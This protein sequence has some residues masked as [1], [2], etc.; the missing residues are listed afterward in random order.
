MTTKQTTSKMKNKKVVRH[1][2]KFMSK[3]EADFYDF[4][5]QTYKAEEIELQPKFEL[6]PTFIKNGVT[7]RAI[8]YIADFRIGNLIFD[9]KGMKTLHFIL[10]YKMFEYKNPDLHLTLIKQCPIKYQQIYGRWIEVDTLAKER[11]QAKKVS[12][13]VS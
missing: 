2:I 1:N 9:V 5:L 4:L 8:T 10:K 11:K 6:Q 12:K 7:H 13:W 3:M